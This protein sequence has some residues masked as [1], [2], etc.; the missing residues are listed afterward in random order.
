MNEHPTTPDSAQEIVTDALSEMGHTPH[1]QSTLAE[2]LNFD[3][4]DW[5]QFVGKIEERCQQGG[6]EFHFLQSPHRL[7]REYA[8]RIAFEASG[9]TTLDC[10]V[11]QVGEALRRLFREWRPLKG[12]EWE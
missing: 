10:T 11:A 1:L 3:T 6:W 5:N 7:L 4:L 9:E 12:K 2:E 8:V